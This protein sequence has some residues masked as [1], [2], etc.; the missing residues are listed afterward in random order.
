MKEKSNLPGPI[1]WWKVWKKE[2]LSVILFGNLFS[3]DTYIFCWMNCILVLRTALNFSLHFNFW[4]H[5]NPLRVWG[6][7]FWQGLVRC[8]MQEWRLGTELRIALA[9]TGSVLGKLQQLLLLS[10]NRLWRRNLRQVAVNKALRMVRQKPMN[11]YK[12]KFYQVSEP[13]HFWELQWLTS[14]LFFLLL[15]SK[16]GDF[17]YITHPTQTET[18][19]YYK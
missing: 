12:N 10:P 13:Q 15:E 9:C 5:W 4:L 3:Y 14:A 19:T 11:S 7:R 8:T 16:E 18:C 2:W 6:I 1:S 17:K